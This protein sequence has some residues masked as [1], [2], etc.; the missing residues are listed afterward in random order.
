[1]TI[2]E[3]F[4]F[5]TDLSINPDNM[6]D[7]LDRAMEISSQRSLEDITDQEKIDEEVYICSVWH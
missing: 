7:Y 4:D 3:L 2:K 6:D 1:M 5:I